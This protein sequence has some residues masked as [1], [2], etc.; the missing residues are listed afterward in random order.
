MAEKELSWGK[1]VEKNTLGNISLP[2]KMFDSF[3][4]ESWTSSPSLT[5][6]LIV[7]SPKPRALKIDIFPLEG[8]EVIKILLKLTD[9]SVNTIEQIR[10][11]TKELKLPDDLFMS[12]VCIEQRFCIYESYIE[13]NKLKVSVDLIKER[14]ASVE[15]ITEVQVQYIE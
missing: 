7:F 3:F 10:E 15:S 1:V 9:F 14:F 5:H 8:S 12:G 4:K 2:K 13:K 11:I 6:V